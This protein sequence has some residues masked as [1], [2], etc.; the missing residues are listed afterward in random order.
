MQLTNVYLFI[1]EIL[2]TIPELKLITWYNGQQAQNVLHITP[3]VY[4]EFPEPLPT[5]TLG[6]V[7]KQQA[8]LKIRVSLLSKILSDNAGQIN[9]DI[10]REHENIAILIFK[11]LQNRR[12]DYN[13][14]SSAI[15]SL[16]RTNF[17]L[18]MQTPAMA[19]TI[20]DFECTITSVNL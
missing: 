1:E 6:A 10:I 8:N 19:A 16:Q 18:N 2:K 3:A 15:S 14:N 9:T 20:Q 4:V 11:K 5:Q 17:E 12:F 7:C 13:G